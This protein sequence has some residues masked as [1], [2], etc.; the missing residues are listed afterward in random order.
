[1]TEEETVEDETPL[2]REENVYIYNNDVKLGCTLTLP[3]IAIGGEDDGPHPAMV[4]ITGSGA[5]DRD[6]T[7]FGFKPFRLL[8]D[9]LTPHG[10]AVLRCDDRGV[11]ESTG[12]VSTSTSKDLAGDVIAKFQ[13]LQERDDIDNERIGLCGHS[14]GGIIAAMVGAEV[15]SI[16]F[17]ISMAASAAPGRDILIAQTELIFEKMEMDESITRKQVDLINRAYEAANTDEGWDEIE[18][19]VR[20]LVA[21]QLEQMTKEQRNATDDTG[22][23]LDQRVTS[24]MAGIQSEWYR[25]FIRHDPA[26]DWRRV[27]Q[28]VLALFGELDLQV[29]PEMNARALKEALDAA[30]N[31]D[32]IIN[33]IPQANHLFQKAGTGSPTE[34]AQLEKEFIDGIL[35]TMADWIKETALH[36][37]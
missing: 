28:P 29:P 2:Y 23:Y 11:G 21:A 17:I 30:G 5:Q 27:N 26:E 3:S 25:F 33:I 4:L 7:I 35:E 13:F 12:G 6:E 37:K 10:I 20:E 18:V 32:Y 31:T 19:L 9:H 14:E 1:M 36:R 24:A 22:Q 8:A 16:A 34:Y 15:E